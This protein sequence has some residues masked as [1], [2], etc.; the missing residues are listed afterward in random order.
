MKPPPSLQTVLCG[1][2]LTIM[3]GYADK[4]FDLVLCDPPY[5]IGKS[6]YRRPKTRY[7][8]AKAHNKFYDEEWDSQTPSKEYFD[9]ILRVS[10]NQ[11][12]FGGNYFSDKLPPSSCWIVWDKDNGMNDFAD[13]ELAWTSFSSAVRQFTFRWQGMLQGDMKNKEQRYHP[14][15]KPVALMKWCLEKYSKEGDS[16][17]DVFM[18][19]GPTLIAAKM[20]NRPVVGIDISPKYVKIVQER[21]AATTTQ[22]F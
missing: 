2:S 5:G 14:T 20:L 21:L 13:C 16:V 15:Q 12:I 19:S 18:G 8:N 9:E 22:L 7:G 10:K 3:K 6:K 11:I 17:L 1:D 4:Q